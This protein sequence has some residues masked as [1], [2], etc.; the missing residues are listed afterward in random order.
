MHQ[1]A[2]QLILAAMILTVLTGCA[3]KFTR[4]RF[5]MITVGVDG[6]EDVRMMIGKPTSDLHD[7]WFYDDLDEHY[8]AL[9]YFSS[10]GLVSGKQWMDSVTGAWEGRNPNTNPPPE[11]EVRERHVKTRRIDDD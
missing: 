8:S 4:E 5:D 2:L 6:R 9:V 7:Q 1:R 11:G 10:D 3:R